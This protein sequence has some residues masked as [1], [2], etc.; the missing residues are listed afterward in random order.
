MISHDLARS[1]ND[2]IATGPRAGEIE[3]IVTEGGHLKLVYTERFERENGLRIRS[4]AEQER[5]RAAW[6]HNQAADE[7]SQEAAAQ[8]EML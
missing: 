6:R 7:R 8:E 1:C 3:W 2:R 5:R 4:A